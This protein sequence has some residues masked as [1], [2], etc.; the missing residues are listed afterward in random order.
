M[1]SEST[2]GAVELQV[3]MAPASGHYYW[4]VVRYRHGNDPQPDYYPR[5]NLGAP[6]QQIRTVTTV[7][8]PAMHSTRGAGITP[9]ACDKCVSDSIVAFIVSVDA[10]QSAQLESDRK[11]DATTTNIEWQIVSQELILRYGQ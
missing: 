7:L 8:P 5:A 10:T 4:L 9:S 1:I 6:D 2:D 3:C 11:R